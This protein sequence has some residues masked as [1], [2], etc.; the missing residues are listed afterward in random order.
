MSGGLSRAQLA[1][2]RKNADRLRG[3]PRGG[4]HATCGKF[5][6]FKGCPI[7]SPIKSGMKRA[8]EPSSTLSESIDPFSVDTL[9]PV[10]SKP[11]QGHSHPEGEYASDV[12][13]TNVGHSYL[14]AE[15]GNNDKEPQGKGQKLDV[16]FVRFFAEPTV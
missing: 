7:F 16:G 14:W 4:V 6:G 11:L 1:Q 3:K 2:R 15:T 5:F 10:K 8:R 9:S 13:H 12:V